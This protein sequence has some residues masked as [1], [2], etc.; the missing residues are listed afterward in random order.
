MVQL[1]Y[2]P[3]GSMN[4][5]IDFMDPASGR[6]SD[7]TFP[8][9]VAFATG[10]PAAIEGLWSTSQVTRATQQVVA[11]VTHRITIRYMPGLRTR[12]FVVYHDPDNG[13]RT[14]SID[15]IIDPDELKVELRLLCIERND[16]R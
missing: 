14:F 6:N 13:D 1:L 10:V 16:G 11:T 15:Q 12:M 9:P 7:G 2:T 3:I 8:T 5:L 4:R